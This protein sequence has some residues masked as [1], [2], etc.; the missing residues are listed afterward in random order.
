L[1]LEGKSVLIQNGHTV[2]GLALIELASALGAEGVYA[3]GSCVHH[4]LL[5]G[6]GAIPLGLVEKKEDQAW[7]TWKT[8]KEDKNISLVLMHEMPSLSML[9]M[10]M[11]VLGEQGSLVMMGSVPK[12]E[13]VGEN[14][15]NTPPTNKMVNK[16]NMESSDVIIGFVEKARVAHEKNTLNLRLSSC[17]QLVTYQ[18]VMASI[19]DDPLAW[20]ED[21]SFLI[22]LL[23]KGLLKPR[24]HK[25][26]YN[27]EE[28]PILQ[29]KIELYDDEGS[30]VCLKSK[31][32]PNPISDRKHLGI[33]G[34]CALRTQMEAAAVTKISSIWRRFAFQREY[35]CTIQGKSSKLIHCC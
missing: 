18:G 23:A 28:V 29:D 33:A 20:K 30:F 8:L 21:V 9:D 13:D 6:A 17:S 3:T 1:Q 35:T 32:W 10:F 19:V 16:V 2:L 5:E 7:E 25:R 24:V 26:V 31:K 14:D 12:A 22:N 11:S 34:S 15:E 27:V 4:S